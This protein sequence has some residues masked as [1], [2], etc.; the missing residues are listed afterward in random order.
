MLVNQIS[1]WWTMFASAY[2]LKQPRGAMKTPAEEMGARIR[3]LRED[4]GMT[5]YDLG[6][7]VGVKDLAI[8]QLEL[9]R[10]VD[11][12]SST[13]IGI[14]REFNVSVD[15]L[16]FGDAPDAAAATEEGPD[17]HPEVEAYLD[18]HPDMDPA[19]ASDLRVFFKRSAMPGIVREL[20]PATVKELRLQRLQAAADAPKPVGN[21]RTMAERDAE[22]RARKKGS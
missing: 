16:L 6:L 11:P 3:K 22:I 1:A 14:A 9:G 13:L 15:F 10:T 5:Q 12:K 17:W 8:G 7:K 2:V 18:E 4:R 21:R 19:L 20:I